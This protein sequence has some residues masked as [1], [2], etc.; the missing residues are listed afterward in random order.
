MSTVPHS[1]DVLPADVETVNLPEV[2]ERLGIPVTRV[3]DLLRDGALLAVRRAGVLVVPEV[4]F[5][6]DDE[7]ARFLPGLVAVLRDGGYDDG[8][9]LK[10]LFEEDE[11]LPGRPADALHGHRAREVMRRAQAMA[12]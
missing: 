5:D 6:D 9:I 1:D 7:V 3:H 8:E 12:F 10:W 2:S 4:F 11:S